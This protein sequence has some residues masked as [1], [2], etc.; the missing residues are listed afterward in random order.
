MTA[1]LVKRDTGE[2]I[3]ADPREIGIDTLNDAGHK[4]RALLA[5]IRAKCIDC[6]N[7][8]PSE[9]AKC[10]A[11]DCALWPYRMRTNPFAAPRKATA[12]SFKR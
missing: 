8:Q 2:T 12:G 10:T 7:H 6:C 3:G 11:V 9:V 1:L 4:K 5:V